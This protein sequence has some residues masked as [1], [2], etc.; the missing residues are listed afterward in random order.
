[1]MTALQAFASNNP[2]HYGNQ[3]STL[4][5]V[6]PARGEFMFMVNKM[7]YVSN[8]GTVVLRSFPQGLHQVEI[9][10]RGSRN[11][12]ELLAS[13]AVV[14]PPNSLVTVELD[15]RNRFQV[16]AEPI[17]NRRVDRRSGNRR[18]DRNRGR[19]RHHHQPVMPMGMAP[20]TFAGFMAQIRSTTFES[21]KVNLAKTVISVHG[22]NVGQ[23]KL[24][25]AEFTFDSN[26]L[27][28]AKFA[29]AYTFDPENYFLLHNSFTFESNARSLMAYAR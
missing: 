23:L 1:M 11:R 24:L 17:S 3:N 4:T 13:D 29:Y 7:E 5:L 10:R 18:Y 22:I 16:F 25:L 26:K 6:A 12:W 8:S 19:D 20:E 14:V 27:D 21:N 2:Y 9:Y 28:V 15:R